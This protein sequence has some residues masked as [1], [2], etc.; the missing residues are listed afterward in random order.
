MHTLGLL[1]AAAGGTWCRPQPLLACQIAIPSLDHGG[2]GFA[3]EGGL[4][5]LFKEGLSTFSEVAGI[6][7]T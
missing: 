6:V 2:A 1:S 3:V 7:P 4:V 5:H